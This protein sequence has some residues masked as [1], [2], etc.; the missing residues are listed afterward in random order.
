MAQGGASSQD[1]G[2]LAMIVDQDTATGM[3]LTGVGHVDLRR[4]SNFLVVDDKTPLVNIED[5]FK[6]FT[7]RDDISVLLI[8][9]SIANTIRH[10]LDAYMRPVPAILE[11][12]SK[13]QPYDPTQDSILARV[14][15]MFGE[16]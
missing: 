3:L 5:A 10:L 4:R 16:G 6:D 9:Q 1:G 8:N 12:P 15:F 13:D 11:V 2:L 14:K 7:N